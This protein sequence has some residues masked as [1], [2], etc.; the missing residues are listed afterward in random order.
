MSARLGVIVKIPNDRAALTLHTRTARPAIYFLTT[1]NI[2]SVVEGA[3][4]HLFFLLTGGI[5]MSMLGG[6][7]KCGVPLC[8]LPGSLLRAARSISTGKN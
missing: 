8:Q 3:F 6:L 5:I 4:F 2:R 7:L 1:T